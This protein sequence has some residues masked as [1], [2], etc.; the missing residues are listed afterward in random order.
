MSNNISLLHVNAR[1]LANKLEYI[2]LLLKLISN[3]F[4]ILPVSE[5]WETEYNTHLIS[6]PGYQKVS[7]MR[8]LNKLGGGAA[9]F[10]KPSLKFSLI[11]IYSTNFESVFIEILDIINKS[12]TSCYHIPTT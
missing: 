6:I 12:K 4:D 3:D 1:S 9:L 10:V 7:Y 8:P 5:T 2:E 11:H